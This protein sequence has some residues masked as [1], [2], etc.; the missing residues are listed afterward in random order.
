M[1]SSSEIRPRRLPWTSQFS[2]FLH[3]F[4]PL[5]I[6]PRRPPGRT[7]LSGGPTTPARVRTNFVPSGL[8]CRLVGQLFTPN[9]AE[10]LAALPEPL[11]SGPTIFGLIFP[12]FLLVALMMFYSILAG[13]QM[14]LGKK[15]MSWQV[16]LPQGSL[17]TR[18][19]LGGSG[20]MIFTNSGSR[21]RAAPPASSSNQRHQRIIAVEEPGREVGYLDTVELRL[22]SFWHQWKKNER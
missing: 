22:S 11:F 8:H 20:G 1:T 17:A 9:S 4:P 16:L 10:P 3:R 18:W 19:Q 7:N 15:V 12:S 14:L 2:R 6:R 5:E 21:Q 13:L